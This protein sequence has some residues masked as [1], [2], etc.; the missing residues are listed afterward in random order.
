MKIAEI[1]HDTLSEYLTYWENN[2]YKG[3]NDIRL[4]IMDNIR[5]RAYAF[6]QFMIDKHGIIVYDKFDSFSD[7]WKCPVLDERKALMFMLRFS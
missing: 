6:C 2:I 3:S 7:T 4:D 5:T 1:N